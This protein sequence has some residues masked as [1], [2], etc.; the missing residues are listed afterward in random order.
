M[1]RIILLLAVG[2][3]L[4]SVGWSLIDRSRTPPVPRMRVEVLNGCGEGGLAARAAQHLRRLGQ[5]VVEVEDAPHAKFA[6]SVLIDRAGKPQMTRR[7]AVAVGPMPVLLE[8]LAEPAAD[9]TLV[10]GRDWESL[11]LF[12]PVPRSV[13]D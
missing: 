3:A 4:A 7:L 13:G 8:R 1:R 11:A 5:D 10:L 9:V 12:A 6:E 2:V